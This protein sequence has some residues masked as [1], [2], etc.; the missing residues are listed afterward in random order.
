MDAEGVLRTPPASSVVLTALKQAPMGVA[1]FDTEMRYL[2][3][4]ARFLTDQGLPGDVMLDGRVHYDVFPEVPQRW[5]EVHARALT[6]GVE[7]KHEADPYVNKQGRLQ[8]IRWSVTPWRDAQGE[9]GGLVL[10]TEVVT[11]SVEARLG[12]EATEAR[13]RAVFDQVAMGVARVA[14]DGRILE[15]ND[16]FC[17]I[18]GYDREA[19]VKLSFQEIT[20]PDD[21]EADLAKVTALLAGEAN[22]F[23]MEKRYLTAQGETVW[24]TLTASLVRDEAG[25]PDYFVSIIDDIGYRKEA[26]A[27]QQHYQ[28]QLRLMI[29]EL[30]HRVKNTL[31]TVQSMASQSMR[32]ETDMDGAYRKFTLRLMGL[33]E[34]H[35]V[36]TRERWHGAALQEVA[37]RALKPFASQ[38][39]GQV[40]IRG[41]QVWLQPGDQCGEVRRPV[42]GEGPGESH[43]EVRRA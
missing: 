22:T 23:S 40:M 31:A 1:I 39:T 29:N 28:S 36:L 14:P 24:I 30:N 2:A 27:Q 37:E 19:L 33:A 42:G 6:L 16:R 21:L 11:E 13:Y 9:I 7:E 20:H 26:E 32:G 25:A 8:W 38:A 10:Y 12:L 5:R 18:A 4:S 3:A 34:V 35:D 41:P 43:L 17:A 15:V